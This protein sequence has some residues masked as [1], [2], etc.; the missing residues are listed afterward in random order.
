MN[1]PGNEYVDFTVLERNV[2]IERDLISVFVFIALLRGLKYFRIFPYTGPTTLSLLDTFQARSFIV[3][4][5]IF[6]YIMLS[7]G[8]S[9]HLAFGT[10]LIITNTLVNSFLTMISLITANISQDRLSAANSAMGPFYYVVSVVLVTM[11]LLVIF[12]FIFGLQIL[13]F[14]F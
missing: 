4:I 10:N 1:T 14:I 13:F 2:D 11:L 7:I 8:V 12:F 5:F 6:V 3:F 9:F